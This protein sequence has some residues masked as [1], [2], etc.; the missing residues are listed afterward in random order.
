MTSRR[1]SPAQEKSTVCL[2][3]I[4]R[5][6]DLGKS[7]WRAEPGR[8]PR[9][10]PINQE[11]ADIVRPRTVARLTV[12]ATPSRTSSVRAAGR[13]EH[14]AVG[15]RDRVDDS[16][17][18]PVVLLH[19]DTARASR[20]R[21]SQRR[22][23]RRQRVGT[24]P[25]IWPDDRRRSRACLQQRRDPPT[26]CRRPSATG[27]PTSTSPNSATPAGGLADQAR[28]IIARLAIRSRRRRDEDGE[29]RVIRQ[30]GPGPWLSAPRADAVFRSRP[31]A[32]RHDPEAASRGSSDQES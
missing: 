2:R 21:R 22:R 9:T 1:R 15:R 28:A 25:L 13:G 19:R 5:E 12:E 20:D 32:A 11:A 16:V 10:V 4:C 29:G 6:H 8:R 27:W 17:T 31:R 18:M 26:A 30:Q 7:A 24:W 23:E 14:A 3:S